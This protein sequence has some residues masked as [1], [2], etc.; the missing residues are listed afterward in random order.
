MKV[1]LHS[2]HHS[3]QAKVLLIITVMLGISFVMVS[4]L[5]KYS[6]TNSKLNQRNNEYHAAVAAAEAATEK[7]LGIITSDFRNNGD[8]YVGQKMNYYRGLTPTK[9]EV[10]EWNNFD[11]MNMA[12]NKGCVDVQYARI[13]GFAPIGGQYGPL[14]AFKDRLRIVSNAQSKTSPYTSVGSVYQDIELSRIPIF[15]YAIFYNVL[16]EIQPGADMTITGPVHGNT[17]IILAPGATLTCNSDITSSGTIS[18]PSS[19]GTIV[20][21]GKHD[22]GVSTLNLP[23]GTNN[24]PAAVRQVIESPPPLENPNS[25]LGQQRFLNK[26]DVVIIVSNNNVIARSGLWNNFATVLPTND[27]FAFVST[28]ASFFNKRE[29]KTVLPVQI[30]VARLVEWNATNSILR[31]HLPM[32]DVRTIYVSDRRTFLATAQTGVRVVN[33]AALPPQGLTVA[34]SSPLYVQGDYNVPSWARGTTNTT[35]SVPASF[36]ADAITILSTNWND[37][38]SLGLLSS[39]IAGD[40]TINAAFITGI[41]ATGP[42]SYSG[43]VENYPRFLENWSGKTLTYNGSMIAMFYSQIAT[44]LW[45]G[46]GTTYGIYNPPIR[47]WSLDQNFQYADKLPPATPNLTVLVRAAWRTPAA[48]TT[49]VLANF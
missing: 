32:T 12:G 10:A 48:F 4:G 5:F 22:S 17:N 45:L 37:V 41:V 21:K 38:N 14:R 29:N 31:P 6:A 34:T 24:N 18:T 9:T 11:F 40:T 28:N 13:P 27:I 44:G 42:L 25:S 16:L 20:Y 33:G 1:F 43:G 35:A 26:A 30:D 19:S 46:T 7:L 39:R 3:S 15:Q 49:N 2:H 23:I 47:K 8:G 36:A